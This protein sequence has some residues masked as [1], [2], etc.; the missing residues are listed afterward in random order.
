MSRSYAAAAKRGAYGVIYRAILASRKF[1]SLSPTAKL[2]FYTL[3]LRLGF[4]QIDRQG[5][6]PIELADLTGLTET[7][8]AM[9]INELCAADIAQ[10]DGKVL[11]IV[12]GLR[13]D[14]SMAGNVSPTVAQGI[15]RHLAGLPTCPITHQF[16]RHYPQIFGQTSAA[17]LTPL[18]P[19]P[20]KRGM[21]KA[22]VV[23][24]DGD[25]VADAAG[26]AGT[27]ARMP[28]A[29]RRGAKASA[30]AVAGTTLGAPLA[31]AL[32]NTAEAF[33]GRDGAIRS[34][35]PRRAGGHDW[36]RAEKHQATIIRQGE[37]CWPNLVMA[38]ERYGA[39]CENKGK[40]GSEYVKDA[41]NFFAPGGLWESF[42][43]GE[44]DAPTTGDADARA[45]RREA[46][47]VL[48]N[49]EV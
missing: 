7:E 21:R 31:D 43:D 19:T 17:T 6:W 35:Y 10:F 24:V 33:Q 39:H 45:R 5:S 25:V 49:G 38:A 37:Y 16:R 22:L 46:E 12:D 26:T 1:S 48:A 20:R 4:A 32:G 47:L 27:P 30:T 18:P 28:S 41:G 3:K 8:A 11:W 15:E 29:K 2:A 14:P 40:S 44:E 13:W 42:A 36:G 9:A 23:D 34:A